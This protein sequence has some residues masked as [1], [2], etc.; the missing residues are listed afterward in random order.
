[1]TE[2]E[3]EQALRETFTRRVAVARPLAADPAGLAI[4][5]AD[6]ARRRRTL[7][8]VALAAVATVGVSTGIAQ[9]GQQPGRPS[10]PTVVLGDPYASPLP[11]PT[12][13][14][15]DAPPNDVSR[16]EVDLILGP[17]LATASGQRLTLPDVGPAER[18]Q[19]LPDG[20]GWAVVGA[21]TAAGRSLWVVLP[22]GAAHLLLAGARD[23]ALSRDGRQVAWREGAELVAAGIVGT[24]VVAA[25]RT[26]VPAGAVPVG[27]AGDAVLVRLDADQPGHALWRPARG[28]L[29]GG[30]DRA[31]LR[32][33]GTRPDGVVVA[34]VSAGTPRRP[35]LALLDPARNLAPVRTG[36][37]PTLS[38]DGRG[39]VSADG[40]WLLVNGRAG[41]V[42]RALL[43]DLDRLGPT[44]TIR[45]AGPPVHGPVAWTPEG[46]AH[47]ADALAGLVRIDVSRVLAGEEASGVPVAGLVD[48]QRP[49]PVGGGS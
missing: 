13:A 3:L 1:M 40:R 39:G 16:G 47:Y 5:R 44:T 45:P 26:P 49:V 11:D 29:K 7:A 35:C 31:T 8:G 12:P 48:G 10:H 28:P 4:R 22:H 9:L 6:R 37:G 43:V 17:V 30:G 36:C 34:Q 21:P 25:A 24:Q 27:F 14:L 41:G 20:A 19:R 38:A 33:Y 2:D 46:T 32:V 42:D 23:I 15:S 18:A